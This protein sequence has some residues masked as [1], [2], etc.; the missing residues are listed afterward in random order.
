MFR[1]HKK[2]CSFR[3]IRYG[4]LYKILL[5][6]TKSQITII[7]VDQQLSIVVLQFN[8]TLI[9]SDVSGLHSE[10]QKIAITARWWEQHIGLGWCLKINELDPRD[11]TWDRWFYPPM[12]NPGSRADNDSAVLTRSMHQRQLYF[13]LPTHHWWMAVIAQAGVTLAR[14]LNRRR[15]GR[16]KPSRRKSYSAIRFTSTAPL[17]I[18]R[19]WHTPIAPRDG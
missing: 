8:Q 12:T 17:L 6:F 9:Y 3:F 16:S 7:T 15:E 5:N 2:V 13:C 11:V 19:V 4:V 10:R 1:S 14:Q 18:N